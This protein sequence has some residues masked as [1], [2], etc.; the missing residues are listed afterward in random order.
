MKIKGGVEMLLLTRQ[1][2]SECEWDGRTQYSALQVGCLC[3]KLNSD[4]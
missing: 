3:A 1:D 2:K 4:N